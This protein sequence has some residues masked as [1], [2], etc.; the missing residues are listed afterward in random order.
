MLEMCL[1]MP[2]KL[3]GHRIVD[4]KDDALGRFLKVTPATF[5][6]EYDPEAAGR[7]LKEVLRIFRLAVV[8]DN[9]RVE[10]AAYL[11]Q[12]SELE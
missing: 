4:K 5:E 10:F 9:F 12:G 8:L 2:H 11:L 6:G 1:V 7:W 3:L